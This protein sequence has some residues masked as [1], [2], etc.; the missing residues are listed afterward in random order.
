M[1]II[2]KQIQRSKNLHLVILFRWDPKKYI[3]ELWKFQFRHLKHYKKAILG[4]LQI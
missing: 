3:L 4:T 2:I 1:Q